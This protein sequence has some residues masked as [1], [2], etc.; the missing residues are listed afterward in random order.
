MHYVE[1]NETSSPDKN[2]IKDRERKNGAP[3]SHVLTSGSLLTNPKSGPDDS[4]FIMK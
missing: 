2:R 1:K 3:K 4:V